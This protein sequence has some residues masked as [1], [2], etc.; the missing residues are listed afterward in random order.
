MKRMTWKSISATGLGDKRMSA[1]MIWQSSWWARHDASTIVTGLH[2]L[3]WLAVG[4]LWLEPMI[5]FL[6]YQFF[7]EGIILKNLT[8]LHKGHTR[9]KKWELFSIASADASCPWA[10]PSALEH[11]GAENDFLL[12]SARVCPAGRRCLT[13]GG[14][15][16]DRSDRRCSSS[17]L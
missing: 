3:T 4:A 9:T 7:R 15:L 12:C 11:C 14:L 5:W 10:W 16:R 13:P 2:R 1:R 8:P 17:S 6:I